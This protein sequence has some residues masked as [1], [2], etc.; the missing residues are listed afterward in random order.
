MP[1][2]ARCS[3][4]CDLSSCIQE[5]R[6]DL[7]SDDVGIMGRIH[8]EGAV[9]CPQVDRSCDARNTALV[10]LCQPLASLSQRSYSV[11]RTI[12]AVSVPPIENSRSAY[13]FQYPKKSGNFARKQSYTLRTSSI[14]DGFEFRVTP[15]SR[16][17]ARL[18]RVSH[19][20]KSS[21]SAICEDISMRKA[22][23]LGE[24]YNSVEELL[25][26][27][28]SFV[29]SVLH[30]GN[31][32]STDGKHFFRENAEA[33]RELG[34]MVLSSRNCTVEGA[35]V[36]W[37]EVGESCGANYGSCE[38]R[39]GVLRSTFH[40]SPLRPPPQSH[41]TAAQRSSFTAEGED[42]L[43]DQLQLLLLHSLG[44]KMIGC[45]RT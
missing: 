39:P 38:R 27:T 43:H 17:E 33:C 6:P 16:S 41:V 22:A 3:L 34:L 25:D 37:L 10:D 19:F 26:L 21:S 12:S 11:K 8:L 7:L 29:A 36:E 4:R 28:G 13:F 32:A 15:P 42:P 18:I 40:S 5:E 44:G 20:S 9:V 23:W 2:S 35:E 1:P 24:T 14:A 45:C 30:L 31:T